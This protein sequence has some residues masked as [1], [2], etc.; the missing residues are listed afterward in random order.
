VPLQSALE[1]LQGAALCGLQLACCCHWEV[2]LQG[3]AAWW[4]RQSA[5]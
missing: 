4:W 3:T 1:P 5:V 2:Q